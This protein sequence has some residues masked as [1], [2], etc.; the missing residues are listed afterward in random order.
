MTQSLRKSRDHCRQG[1]FRGSA[2]RP[3]R[4]S[5]RAGFERLTTA[6]ATVLRTILFVWMTL[7]LNHLQ[8]F[9][10]RLQI[11][12]QP[13]GALPSVPRSDSPQAAQ[14][15]FRIEFGG[16]TVGY[17]MVSTTSPFMDSGSKRDVSAGLI[18]RIRETRLQ[19]RRIGSDL[20]VSARLETV[21]TRDGVLR[22]WSLRRTAA[23]ESSIER[24][25][26]WNSEK[27]G[28]DVI[29]KVGGLLHT[30][31][32]PAKVPPR[33]AILSAWVEVA[34][35]DSQRLWTS[36]VLFPETAA[37][38]DIQIHAVGG[39]SLKL[40]DGKTIAITR[41][42]YWPSNAPEMK[43]S[44]YYDDRF[45]LVRME[46]PLMGQT[47]KLE[48]TDAAGALGES[49]LAVL[50]LQ[51]NSVV[52][53]KRPL[54][55]LD[56]AESLRLSVTVGPAEQIGLPSS[57]FQRVDQTAANEARVTLIRP[58]TAESPESATARSFRAIPV[59][60]VFTSASRW[61]DSDD[62]G[63]K[64]MA[65]MVAGNASLP[66]EKCN[67]LTRHVGKQMRLSPF[68]TSLQPASTIARNL[69]GDCTEH[70]VLLCALMRSQGIPSRVALGFVYVPNPASFAPH[71]WTEAFLDGRWI[72]FDSTRGPSGIGLTHLKV[73]DSA[74]T[75]E[76]ASGSV[77]FVPLLSFLGRATID[78]V[79]M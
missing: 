2:L 12:G 61:I 44:L 60:S 36:P 72:P 18:R 43:S 52:P 55:N 63:V 4:I 38:V 17:E 30:E 65:V 19:L 14:E 54:T 62:E 73:A 13:P 76:I 64:R 47:L 23:H 22:S 57:D 6:F 29:E 41:F 48:R 10:Q 25:G 5:R 51:F 24:S 33:S 7:N 49:T 66:L 77:L 58:V 59:D 78:V 31:L 35:R 68:S 32:L 40:S 46:Q 27:S 8:A 71:M 3:S 37:I 79:P 34:S 1:L 9:G 20:S 75:D 39:Q 53:V 42:D 50:D 26:V 11:S 74:L 70:A 45:S 28:F 16:K 21:E 69:R 56:R 15:W 67:R